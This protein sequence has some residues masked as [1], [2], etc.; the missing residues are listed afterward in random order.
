MLIGFRVHGSGP[1]LARRNANMKLLSP[2]MITWLSYTAFCYA[3]SCQVW[4]RG[5][6]FLPLAG[7]RVLRISENIWKGLFIGAVQ[8]VGIG[9]DVG[10]RPQKVFCLFMNWRSEA[11]SSFDV[12]RSMFDVR[13][14]KNALLSRLY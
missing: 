10:S 7:E 12:Q 11:I 6:W 3:R 8:G 1:A 13:R 4:A 14:S 5:S 2:L 9:W